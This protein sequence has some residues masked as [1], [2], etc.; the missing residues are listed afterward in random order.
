MRA[1]FFTSD[2]GLAEVNGFIMLV[3]QVEVFGVVRK[4]LKKFF[5]NY[6]DWIP[7]PLCD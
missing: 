5:H 1:T 2:V 4:E 7:G 6:D 3:M